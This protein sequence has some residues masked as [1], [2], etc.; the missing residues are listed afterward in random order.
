MCGILGYFSDTDLIDSTNF[1]SSLEAL[2]RRGPDDNGVYQYENLY[3]GQTRLSIVDLKGGKQPMVSN[4]GNYVIVFNGEI[5]NYKRLKEKYSYNYRSDSDT[6]VILAGYIERSND[7]LLDLEGMFAFAIFDKKNNVIFT[8]RD[9]FGIKPLLYYHSDN[10][11]AFSSEIKGFIDLL[12]GLTLNSKS[13]NNFITRKFIPAPDTIYNEINKLPA[14]HS[15]TYDLVN[16]KI[17]FEKYYN[18]SK[19]KHK[20]CGEESLKKCI[21]ESIKKH[22]VADVK[23]SALLSGGVDSTIITTYAQRFLGNLSTYTIG[24]E[25]DLKNE[26]LLFSNK[27]ATQLG[28]VHNELIVDRIEYVDFINLIEYFDEPFADHAILANYLVAKAVG[29]DCKVVLSG[30]GGDEFFYGY[31]SYIKLSEQSNYFMSHIYSLFQK[32]VFKALPSS[33]HQYKLRQYNRNINQKYEEVYYNMFGCAKEKLMKW[34]KSFSYFDKAEV[35]S[36]KLFRD[37][38]IAVNLPEYYLNKV[39]KASMINSLEVRV[40]F[41]D[42]SI[43]NQVS[44]FDIEKHINSVKGKLLLKELFRMDLP[45]YVINRRKQGFVRSWQSLLRDKVNDYYSEFITAEFG[46]FFGF[47]NKFINKLKNSKNTVS[48]QILWRLLV[49]GIFYRKNRKNF[50]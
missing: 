32:T 28:T 41:I 17:K 31:N 25:D 50:E 27:V 20:R 48:S 3:L 40:P 14:G 34:S 9:N 12:P 10:C 15:L 18:Y 35:V 13:V 2:A 8:A 43:F 5:Y 36:P 33:D 23:V 1:S 37:Y 39:D 47:N 19:V 7:V 29:Q 22:L 4:C 26:D 46:D 6:E 11:F 38:D 45:D 24:F 16:K 30:D 21:I 49:L 44:C 42:K